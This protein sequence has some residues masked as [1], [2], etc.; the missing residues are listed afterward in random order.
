M[1]LFRGWTWYFR[2]TTYYIVS[3]KLKVRFFAIKFQF[4]FQAMMSVIFGS[5]THVRGDRIDH[6]DAAII[7]MNHRTRLDW[8][9]FWDALFKIDPWLLTTEKISLKGILKYVPGA[10]NSLKWIIYSFAMKILV[11]VWTLWN[12]E[13]AFRFLNNFWKLQHGLECLFLKLRIY[14]L[15]E[16]NLKGSN[17]SKTR[18]NIFLMSILFTLQAGRCRLTHLFSWIGVSLQTQDDSTPFLTTSSIS[19]TI[20]RF[21]LLSYEKSRRI[22]F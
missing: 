9:F 4:L 19:A 7:I 21:I 17:L 10:G 22:Y 12:F 14:C 1:P 11:A 2:L 16:E 6:A 13:K 15:S 3:L 20:I 8:L 18:L 5:R